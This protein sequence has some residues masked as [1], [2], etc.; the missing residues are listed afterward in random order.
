MIVIGRGG[1][2]VKNVVGM[3]RTVFNSVFVMNLIALVIVHVNR[4]AQM[5]VHVMILLLMLIV[6]IA[7]RHGSCL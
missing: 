6:L 7:Q 1:I 2:V 4:F 3:I 5:D